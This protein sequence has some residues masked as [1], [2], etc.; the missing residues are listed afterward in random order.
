MVQKWWVFVSM[1]EVKMIFF[2]GFSAIYVTR[3]DISFV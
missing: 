2:A 3:Y 1:E